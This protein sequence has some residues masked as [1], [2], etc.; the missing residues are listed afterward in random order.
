MTVVLLVAGEILRLREELCCLQTETRESLT[1]QDRLAS[2]ARDL[3]SRAAKYRA[4]V[5]LTV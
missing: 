3:T 1:S 4:Q 2:Q 5:R